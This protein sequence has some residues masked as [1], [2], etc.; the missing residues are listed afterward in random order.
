MYDLPYQWCDRWCGR[1]V[2]GETCG[3]GKRVI[4]EHL[5]RGGKH[6]DLHLVVAMDSGAR[7][8]ASGGPGKTRQEDPWDDYG[9]RQDDEEAEAPPP[10]SLA[11]ARLPSVA[12]EYALAVLELFD[13]TEGEGQEVEREMGGAMQG[14]LMIDQRLTAVAPDLPHDVEEDLH[15]SWRTVP[16]LLMVE[17]V[18]PDVAK[19]VRK[20]LRGHKHLSGDRWQLARTALRQHLAE[21]WDK[22]EE[23][24]RRSMGLL[25]RRKKAPSPFKIRKGPHPGRAPIPFRRR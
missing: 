11:A 16:V 4:A 10:V 15:W 17:K 7:G 25:V 2:L 6:E 19:R 18:E 9:F 24:D 13:T 20:F 5:D 8:G 23:D 12:R 3:I 1:C 21:W 14:A 22:I